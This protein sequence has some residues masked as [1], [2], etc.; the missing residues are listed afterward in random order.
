[1]E[2]FERQ[3][4]HALSRKEP[5]PWFEAKVLAAVAEQSKTR[6]T[7][8]GWLFAARLRWVSALVTAVV[9]ITGVAWKREQVVRERVEGQAAKARL[10][11][12]LKIT[13]SKLQKIEQRLRSVQ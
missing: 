7:T 8:W 2:D 6:R 12:A 9:L 11:L 3:L 4:K 10:E 13:S 5:S 1:M